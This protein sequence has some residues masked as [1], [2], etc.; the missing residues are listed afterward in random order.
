MSISSPRMSVLRAGAF[1]LVLAV[2]ASPAFAAG[3]PAAKGGV[4]DEAAR[5]ITV[6]ESYVPQFGLTATVSANYARAGMITVDAGLDVPDPALRAKLQKMAPRVRDALRSALAEYANTHYRPGA[7]PD[8]DTIARMLQLAINRE[9]G[10]AGA[11]V[12]LA[13]VMVQR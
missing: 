8:P 12:L 9:T 4:N 3:K 5:R 13:N 6:A 1:A 7:A 10:G 11:K 2:A